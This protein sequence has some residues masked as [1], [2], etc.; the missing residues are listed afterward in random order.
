MSKRNFFSL[1]P[2]VPLEIGIYAYVIDGQIST[3]LCRKKILVFAALCGS[4]CFLFYIFNGCQGHF[5]AITW[6]FW[7]YPY[8]YYLIYTYIHTCVL[9]CASVE[10]F[11][12]TLR[13]YAW[14]FGHTK[15]QL[16]RASL[17]VTTVPGIYARH[18]YIHIYFVLQPPPKK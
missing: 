16:S 4:C 13:T 14:I 15:T 8:L 5:I 12:N 2:W 18:T 11:M 7:F 9:L 10:M 17:H 3:M 1:N 6:Q